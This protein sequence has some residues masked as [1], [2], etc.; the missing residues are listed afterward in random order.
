MNASVWTNMYLPLASERILVTSGYTWRMSETL[1][2]K[3]D[4]SEGTKTKGIQFCSPLNQPSPVALSSYNSRLIPSRPLC[5]IEPYSVY[6]MV[7]KHSSRNSEGIVFVSPLPD[8]P[9]VCAVRHRSN[10]TELQKAL[11]EAALIDSEEQSCI[12]WHSLFATVNAFRSSLES[13]RVLVIHPPYEHE[14]EAF[15]SCEHFEA[16]VYKGSHL[17]IHENR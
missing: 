14:H 4:D 13:L 11:E 3:M 5:E 9:D 8:F 17:P 7:C 10:Q 6:Y 1:K 16:H 12:D 15:H 2:R